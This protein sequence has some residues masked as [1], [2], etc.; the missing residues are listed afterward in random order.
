ML[1]LPTPE[2]GGDIDDL[3]PFLNVSSNDGFVLASAWMIGALH[4]TGPY[5]VLILQGEQGSAKT[6]TARFLRALIDP[7]LAPVR[8]E[9]REP[10]DL[11][12][13]ANNGWV[14][15]FDNLSS[16][17]PW[18]SD[19]L[20]RLSTGGGFGTRV[21]Y[22]DD[23]EIIFQAKRPA[24]LTGI[25]DLA[26]RG[27]LLDRAL[28]V[29]L[30][31]IR[32]E[33][34]QS[35]EQLMQ[36][37]ELAKP[38]LI[39]SLLDAV[40]IASS[41]QSNVNLDRRPRM[42]DFTV[43]VAAAERALGWKAGTFLN[44][45][46]ANRQAAN[47][48]LLDTPVGDAVRRLTLPWTGTATEL[49]AALGTFVDRWTQYSRSWP[50]TPQELSGRLRRLAPSFRRLGILIEFDREGGTG[51]RLIA[52]SER[53][54]SASS[55]SSHSSQETPGQPVQCQTVSGN[56]GASDECDDEI[57]SFRVEGEL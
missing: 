4:P 54:C 27:D 28:I 19:G 49:L 1:A 21:L 35:E 5:P 47:A 16:L 6:T 42:A 20:C 23:E 9:P 10:R 34:C 38:R 15:A 52:I 26:V 25:E 14:C 53:A 11:M 40:S 22:T 12:I 17:Q 51:R 57:R 50:K 8:S 43:W 33:K 31:C 2:C 44:T 29:E 3:R 46:T 24:I 36:N 39:G 45:Y 48:I 41:N 30:P 7:N 32:E 56:R 37:F 13:A 55:H 18:L